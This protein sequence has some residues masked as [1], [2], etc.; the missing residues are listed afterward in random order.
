MKAICETDYYIIIFIGHGGIVNG[1]DS[2]QLESS[3][4]MSNDALKTKHL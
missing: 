3:D 4:I 2:I 1:V